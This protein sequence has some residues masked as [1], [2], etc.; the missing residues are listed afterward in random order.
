[1]SLFGNIGEGIKA[2]A[3]T[4]AFFLTGDPQSYGALSN[5]TLGSS[6]GI[7]V[8]GIYDTVTGKTAQRAQQAR[9]RALK[10][11][12]LEA[13]NR[14]NEEVRKFYSKRRRAQGAMVGSPTMVNDGGNETTSLLL[15]F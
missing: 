12:Q 6:F 5:T 13:Q 14:R 8:K 9:Q 3:Q 10:Q 15:K 11:S 7:P 2:G 1:M 4:T